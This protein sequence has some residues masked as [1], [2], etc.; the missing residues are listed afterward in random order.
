MEYL[1]GLTESAMPV[2]EQVII[3][4]WSTW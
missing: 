2:K 4:T 3:Q 1:V